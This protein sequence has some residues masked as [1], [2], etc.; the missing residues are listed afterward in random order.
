MKSKKSLPFLDAKIAISK[1][2]FSVNKKKKWITN[3]FSREKVHLIRSK[4]DC[5]LSTYK[6]VNKDNSKLDCRIK[7]LEKLSPTRVIIDKNLNLKKKLNIYKTSKKIKTYVIIGK[8]NK[9]KENFFKSKNIKLI[10]MFKNKYF[11]YEE[12]LSRLKQLG[13]SRILC[14]SGLRTTNFL[15]KKKLIHNL[16]VFTSANRLG[17]NGKNSYKYLLDQLKFK[18]KEKINVNLSGDQ[19]YKFKIK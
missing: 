19:L 18:K 13:F 12:M 17:K 16:Y 11:S 4:Y 2:F 6:T 10:K 5:I 7:G 1:D 3:E 8:K 14:D 9:K 15:I